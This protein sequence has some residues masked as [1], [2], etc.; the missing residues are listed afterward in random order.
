MAA[1]VAN[2]FQH[3]LIDVP[4]FFA[5][6][7]KDAEGCSAKAQALYDYCVSHPSPNFV[8]SGFPQSLEQFHKFTS[9]TSAKA[10]FVS[11]KA[12]KTELTDHLVKLKETCRSID[13]SVFEP[14]VT[15]AMNAG[16][17]IE[18]HIKTCTKE[19]FMHLDLKDIKEQVI[20]R[21]TATGKKF[22][23]GGDQEFDLYIEQLR[24]ILY[25]NPQHRKFVLTNFPS[26]LE[27]D[28]AFIEKVAKFTLIE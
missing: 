19:G 24:K 6:E 17:E 28:K 4:K 7:A 25:M 11:P 8:L 15:F 2:R 9:Y 1:Q 26:S 23:A 13:G 21:K 14:T 20:K 12:E 27:N 10:V 3:F 18:A 5:E 22:A 16:S